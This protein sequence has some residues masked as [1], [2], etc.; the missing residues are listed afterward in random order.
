MS[1]KRIGHIIP[2]Q[3]WWPCEA[4][5]RIPGMK[6]RT[7]QSLYN[8]PL[9][10]EA[11][12][13][14]WLQSPLGEVLVKAQRERLAPVISRVFG[15]HVLQLSCAPDLNML[16]DCPVNH[17]IVF[18]PGWQQDRDLPV[19]DIETLPLATD[20]MDAVLL[21][22]SLDFTR[23]SHRLL[24]EATRVLRP[25]GRLI[26]I[27]FNPA[28]LWGLS[29]L[30]RWR[31][32]IPWGGR[33]ISRRRLA[34]WLKLL[35]FQ[36]ETVSYGGYMLPA[37]H[38]RLLGVAPDLERWFG[39]FSNPLGAFYLVVASK[40]RVPL[41]PVMPKWRSIRPPALGAPIADT[42][43]V[44]S[45]RGTVVPIRPAGDPVRRNREPDSSR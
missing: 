33:F 36:V 25:G 34:D 35:D 37:G 23:D 26:I 7:S 20:S 42:G 38:P 14:G 17:K 28:S 4:G 1:G 10:L 39:S 8:N 31:K 6:R 11:A 2:E 13:T 45:G 29:K 24:R 32:Q 5:A 27:G 40:Q 12:L 22:H 16:V 30:V 18:A 9:E 43:R 15:Y 41:I 44:A 3:D 19:A 21:H